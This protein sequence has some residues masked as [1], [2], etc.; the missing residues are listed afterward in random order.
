MAKRFNVNGTCDPMRHYMVN[1]DSRLESIR[2]MVDLGEYFTINRARQYGKTTTLYALAKYLRNS[3]EVVSLD[4]QSIASSSY[5]NEKTFTA[6][7]VEEL[8]Y[9]VQDFPEGIRE[10]LQIFVEEK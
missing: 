7:F 2:E 8:L 1:L 3:Y 6:A 10:A 5:E 9:V 4:F